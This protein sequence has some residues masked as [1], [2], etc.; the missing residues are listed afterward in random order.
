MIQSGAVSPSP[1]PSIGSLLVTEMI[2][3]LGDESHASVTNTLTDTETILWFGGHSLLGLATTLP[4]FGAVVSCTVITTVSAA[5][6]PLPSS[7][8]SVKVCAPSATLMVAVGPV[9]ITLLSS[10]VQVKV[11]T[12]PSGSNDPEPFNCTLAPLGPVHSTVG[13]GPAF[14]TGGVFG[15]AM[16]ASVQAP[17]PKVP[18]TST[19]SVRS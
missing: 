17:R 16:P 9:A 4:I 7:T 18:A 15:L 6:P 14:R 2:W 1:R 13:S 5:V 12:S 8:V 3:Q 10:S 19:S 11:S